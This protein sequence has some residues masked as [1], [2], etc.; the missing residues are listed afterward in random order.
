[1]SILTKVRFAPSPTGFMH[2][3]NIKIAILNYLFAKKTGGVFV[4]RIDDTDAKRSFQESENAILEDLH[5]MGLEW[6]EFYRQSERISGYKAAMKHLEGAGRIYPCYE[7]REELAIKK[8]T[9]ARNGIPPIYDRASLFLGTEEKQRLENS[10]IP[11]YWRF[12]LS[13][14]EFVEWNDLV[15]G[16]IS[17]PLNSMSDPVLIKPDGSFV[18]I[19]TS[20]VDDIDIG[21]THIIRGDDHMTNTAVQLDIF[22]AL[23]GKKL[24]FAH[25]PLMSAPN[26]HE[27]SKRSDS[28]FSLRNMR[29]NG[30]LPEAIANFL[31]S[32]GTSN[33]PNPRDTLS[34]LVEKFSF[35]KISLAS[36]KFYMDEL[37]LF[38]RKMLSEKTFD[39]IKE[40]LESYGLEDISEDIWYAVRNNIES[41]ADLRIWHNVFYGEIGHVTVDEVFLQQMLDALDS[42]ADFDSWISKLKQ[43]SS[44]HGKDLY[45]PI[46]LVL[47]GLEHGP[48]LEKIAKILGV[49]RLKHRIEKC[50]EKQKTK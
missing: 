3:G 49:R 31:A 9:Q 32:L 20:I 22:A 24:E 8:K 14:N 6:D 42:A 50:I 47:T 40:H 45:N 7:T 38:S 33:S 25:I 5:W 23:G 4:L 29:K 35:A 11:V 48:E 27:V 43:T 44:K 39:E 19:L 2:A 12:K 18:Y 37:K 28:I 1:M 41:V 46:R 17:I 34:D 10:G 36:S 15:H 26:N 16:K 30:I 13:D 21:I